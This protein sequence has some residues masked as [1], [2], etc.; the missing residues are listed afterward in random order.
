MKKTNENK[1]PDT[2]FKY[3]VVEETGDEVYIEVS[4]EEYAREIAAGIRPDETLQPGRHKFIR[5]G[6]RKRH[7]NFDLSKVKI[8]YN[9]TLSLPPEVYNYFKQLAELKQETSCAEVM[10]KILIEARE[11]EYGSKQQLGD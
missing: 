5:G 3:R 6:F 10:E 11:K 8:R 4:P 2:T 9:I 1:K 7:P